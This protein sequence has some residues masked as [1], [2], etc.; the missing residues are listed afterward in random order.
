M[1]VLTILK[2]IGIVLLCILGFLLLLVLLILF[3]P[4]RYRIDADID[5]PEADGEGEEK[6]LKERAR[7]RVKVTYLLSALRGTFVWPAKEGEE[8]LTVRALFFRLYP[9]KKKEKPERKKRAGRKE[10]EEETN[11]TTAEENG[12][13]ETTEEGSSGEGMTQEEMPEVQTYPEAP[14]SA[15]EQE[16]EPENDD[17]REDSGEEDA[18]NAEAARET[19]KRKRP[20]KRLPNPQIVIKKIYYTICGT[21][22]KIDMVRAT[23]ESSVYFRAKRV[24]LNELK[25]VIRQLLPRGTRV[26][27]TFGAKD[28][29]TTGDVLSILGMLYPV[30]EDRVRVTPVFEEEV[31]FGTARVKGRIIPAV[32]AFSFLRCY[33]NRDVR[34]IV[35][36]VKKIREVGHG[37]EQE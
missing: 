33:L 22:A 14:E 7:A 11:E 27:L 25:R 3:S 30:L 31:L 34:K 26:D 19:R 16:P 5:A 18:G 24:L 29:K 13:Y 32:L 17:Q 21:C 2:W 4:V 9:R 15:G 37:R 35:K 36:R 6:P 12:E 23:I 10:P 28:P 20:R 1:I 8:A